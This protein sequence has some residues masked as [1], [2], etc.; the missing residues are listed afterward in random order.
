MDIPLAIANT[1]YQDLGA[2][3]DGTH[4]PERVWLHWCTWANTE[5]EATCY[6]WFTHGDDGTKWTVLGLTAVGA[7]LI[8][9][10]STDSYWTRQNSTETAGEVESRPLAKSDISIKLSEARQ[11]RNVQTQTRDVRVALKWSLTIEGVGELEI[12]PTQNDPHQP[13]EL[14]VSRLLEWLQP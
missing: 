4:A 10:N 5:E 11:V 2:Y 8:E 12:A 14:F 7:V 6:S 9:G 1:R 3:V 13:Q